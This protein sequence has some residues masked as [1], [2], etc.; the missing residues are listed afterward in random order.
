MGPPARDRLTIVPPPTGVPPVRA[1][2]RSPLRLVAGPDTMSLPELV[3]SFVCLRRLEAWPELRSLLADDALLESIAAAGVAGPDATIEAMRFAAAGET[4][5]VDA[6]ELESLDDDALLVDCSLV[7]KR[8]GAEVTTVVRS[9]VTGRA[10]L[11]WRAQTVHSRADAEA[12]LRRHG[13]DLGIR[14]QAAARLGRVEQIGCASGAALPVRFMGAGRC[15]SW[16][17]EP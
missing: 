12:I 15:S 8:G 14:G 1:R 4:H 16:Q 3:K 6:Y 9:L 7:R 5:T 10:G 2:S 11:I 13:L 17:P